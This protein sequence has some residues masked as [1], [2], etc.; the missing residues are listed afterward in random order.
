MNAEQ[1]KNALKPMADFAPAVLAAAEIVAAAEVA[2]KKINSDFKDLLRSLNEKKAALEGEITTLAST[3]TSL[4]SEIADAQ[5]SRNEKL[6]AIQREIDTAK[7]EAKT[8]K[9]DS[10]A[11]M[12]KHRDLKAKCEK[13]G[14]EFQASRD[15]LAAEFET[16]KAN[17]E[18]W[19]K[20]HGL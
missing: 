7:E 17:F 9:A 10:A 20:E 8:A 1:I 4:S 2:E 14:T 12:Q 15:K 19:K 11:A 5:A 16:L 6:A 13:E 18:A 3:K